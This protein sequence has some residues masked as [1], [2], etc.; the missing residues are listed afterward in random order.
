M[1]DTLD[2]IPGTLAGPD[3][4]M[5]TPAIGYIRVS[6]AR[7]EMISPD[8]QRESITKWAQRTGHCVVDWVEDLDKSGRNFKRRIMGVIERVESGEARVIAVWKYSRFGRTRT[9]VPANLARVE[10][11][12]GQLLSATE[13]VDARTAIGRFQRGMIMEF[14]AFESYRACEQWR[15]THEWRRAHGLPSA[16]GKRWGYIWHP[17]RVPTAGGGFR[18][19]EERYEVDPDLKEIIQQLYTRYTAGEGFKKLARW[20]NELGIATT[21]GGM[22]SDTAMKVYLDSGFAAGFLR[23]HDPDCKAVPYLNSCPRHKLVRHPTLGHQPIIDED[24]WKAFQRRRTDVKA[25]APRSRSAIYPLSGLGVCGLCGTSAR[26]AKSGNKDYAYLT[27][28]RRTSKGPSACAG[29]TVGVGVAMRVV[30][31]WLENE[32]ADLL[33]GEAWTPEGGL[34]GEADA[35]QK[36]I[37]ERGRLEKE[38]ARLERAIAKHLRVF[39][40]LEDDDPT[41]SLDAD[42]RAALAVLRDDKGR[43]IARLAALDADDEPDQGTVQRAAATPVMMALLEDWDDMAPERI[44][45]LLRSL[46]RGV[47][48]V[49]GGAPRVIPIWPED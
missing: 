40:E 34:R 3:L 38:K 7:E 48:I 11:V 14:N 43:C 30:H 26:R 37:A 29:L 44:N 1:T 21:R 36:G 28:G 33:T 5:L 49:D 31:D 4:A 9:G 39:A 12:G 42:F 18:V 10:K 6:M 23:V 19:Q 41:G 2:R 8:L 20:L 35:R 27:C 22:W 32:V 24:T 16:G 13:E 47:L 15:E 45:V 25:M 17:R 46:V